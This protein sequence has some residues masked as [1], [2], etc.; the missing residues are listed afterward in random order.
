MVIPY[1][2]SAIVG[3]LIW[4][5]S[6]NQT[7]SIYLVSY[8]L[9]MMAKS[10]GLISVILVGV[11]CSRVRNKSLKLGPKKIIAAIAV[12]GGIVAFRVFDPA[13][14]LESEQAIE[15]IGFL[16]LLLSLLADGFVPD[17]QA[18]IKEKY[19]PTPI[20]MLVS[21]NKWCAIFAL[22]YLIGSWKVADFIIY[23]I[24]HMNFTWDMLMVSVL[25]FVGQLF[26]Y[27][28]IKMFRQHIVPFVTAT[29]KIFTVGLSIVYF[30]H[31]WSGA[32]VISIL[33]VLGVTMHEFLEN[34]GKEE[35]KRGE[36]EV[37][38]TVELVEEL[39][40]PPMSESE[41]AQ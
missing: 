1:K 41:I 2:N 16:L 31:E 6:I 14:N 35:D 39:E 36:K 25:S 34:I 26:V 11:L 17:F 7:E 33:V 27:R 18:E 38:T 37:K 23:C 24:E 21:V 9:I 40:G 32:Q 29:R 28:M 3:F 13:A 8:P 30:K 19:K 20:Q 12:S 5:S 10:C 15:L 22:V 4:M